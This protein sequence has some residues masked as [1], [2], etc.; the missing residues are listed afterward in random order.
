MIY[1]LE[2]AYPDES[3]RPFTARV[4]NGQEQI[5]W[6]NGSVWWVVAPK[7]AAMRSQAADVIWFDEAGEYS[8]EQTRDL[9]EGALPLMDTR[10]AG[11]VIISGTPAK[12]RAGLLWEMLCKAREGKAR[13]GIVDFS[14]DPADDPTS[15]DVWWRVHPG[16][17]SGLTDIDVIRERFEGMPLASFA[18]EYLCADPV[19][20]SISAI[21]PDDWKATTAEDFLE[22][23]AT[24]SIAYATGFGGSSGAIA[25]AWYTEDG[26]PHVQLLEHRE[27]ISWMPAEVA[28]ILRDSR[29]SKVL[30]D[31]IGDNLAVWQELQR[32]KGLALA[33]LAP[34]SVK[35]HAAGVSLLL[36]AVSDRALVHA[37]DPS[38]DS[39][40]D[41]ASIRYV[42]DSR[43]FGR[44]QST[45]DVSP[46]EAVAIALY[47][48]S[49]NR[50]KVRYSPK[51]RTF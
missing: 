50:P 9:V 43:L 37:T 15:E 14:M 44:K 20:A 49:G 4:G 7:A 21:D 27:G 32:K 39:A 5:R 10:P 23:P 3:S 34:V 18:R 17:A 47:H 16:L 2:A 30:F 33:N 13:Y 35:E 12:T 1:A 46:L 45:N 8:E 38:L 29:Q 42:N 41:G 28:K 26:R 22:V 11:Q 40:A 19:N 25:A 24:A 6:E 51:A 48:A 36:S 31:R